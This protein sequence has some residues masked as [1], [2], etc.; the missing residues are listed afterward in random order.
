M[1]GPAGP[2]A[3]TGGPSVR[4][5]STVNT[6]VGAANDAPSSCFS[7]SGE[8]LIFDAAKCRPVGTTTAV[9]NII[10][11]GIYEHVF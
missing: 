1:S 8:S 5:A 6:A 7:V 2:A 9:K 11:Q 10:F 4:A 3:P